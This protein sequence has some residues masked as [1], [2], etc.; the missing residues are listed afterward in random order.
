MMPEAEFQLIG[1]FLSDD[2]ARNY[3]DSQKLS[4][5]AW[6]AKRPA[7]LTG[8]QPRQGLSLRVN[9]ICPV[10]PHPEPGLA[11]AVYEK[12]RISPS[13]DVIVQCT[14]GHWAK[15]PCLIDNGA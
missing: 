15:Y 10:G 1:G 4:M 2:Q 11:D 6:N 13:D 3:S 12:C 5:A 9:F 7:V 14:A 8:L